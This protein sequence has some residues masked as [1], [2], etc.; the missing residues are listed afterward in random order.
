[1]TKDQMLTIIKAIKTGNLDY[2][3]QL[4]SDSHTD[5]STTPLECR[6][7]FRSLAVHYASRYGQLEIV[8]FLIEKH[9]HLLNIA[10]EI[11]Y[12]PLL[13]AAAHGHHQVVTYLIFKGV[14]LNI[15]THRPGHQDHHKTA[16]SMALHG[17]HYKIAIKIAASQGKEHILPFVTS[18]SQAISLMNLD[19]DLINIFMADDRIVALMSRTEGCRIT[20]KT[21]DLYKKSEKRPSSFIQINLEKKVSCVYNPVELI[22]EGGHG[23]VRLFQNANG[24]EIAVKSPRD[25]RFGQV[26]MLEAEAEFQKKAYPHDDISMIF[27][28][29]KRGFTNRFLMP[30]ILGLTATVFISNTSSPHQLAE[31]ILLIGQE[32]QRIHA[33]GVIH[34]DLSPTNM[35]VYFEDNAYKIRLIDFGCASLL[36]AESAVIFK[37]GNPQWHAPEVIGATSPIKPNQNQDVYS[38]GFTLSMMLQHHSSYQP[39][40]QL[41]PSIGWFI[42]E[43]IDRDPTKRPALDSFCEALRNELYSAHQAKI[44]TEEL[45]TRHHFFSRPRQQREIGQP[46][47]VTQDYAEPDGP[48]DRCCVI[49]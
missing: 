35:M 6:H 37:E 43:S 45:F 33:T 3:S 48:T 38:L 20:K 41:F 15:A 31:I 16:I 36:S 28:F 22:G 25:D 12:T 30:Y 32:L 19:P 46:A 2:L 5:W 1:M 9:L 21:I 17:R 23:I 7:N 29:H 11:G 26:K 40:T 13:Y 34:G 27:E 39:L 18:G 14:D 4:L 24:Q 44:Q 49:S 47:L 10:D 8:R 42:L